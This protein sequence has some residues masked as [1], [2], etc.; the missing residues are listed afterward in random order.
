MLYKDIQ[1]W[2]HVCTQGYTEGLK[3]ILMG[4]TAKEKKWLTDR[5]KIR[6]ST[7]NGGNDGGGRWGEYG[8]KVEYYMRVLE[9]KEDIYCRVN[10]G[11][12]F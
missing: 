3:Q 4:L 5:E 1:I 12:V 9:G 11:D 8:M 2:L 7:K 6:F 10:G